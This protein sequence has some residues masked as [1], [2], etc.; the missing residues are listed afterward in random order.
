MLRFRSWAYLPTA[1]PEI[2]A[3]TKMFRHEYF[4]NVPYDP[5]TRY[6]DLEENSLTENTRTFYP[7]EF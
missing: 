4:E 2:Y 7:L 1:E 3:T 5:V 6:I